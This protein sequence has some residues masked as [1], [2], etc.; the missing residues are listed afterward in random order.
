MERMR[1]VALRL[2]DRCRSP[3][4]V[5]LLMEDYAHFVD[6]IRRAERASSTAWRSCTAATRS[7]PGTQLANSGAMPELVDELLVEHYDPAYLRSIDRNFVQFGAGA[8]AG[9]GRHRGQRLSRG[10]RRR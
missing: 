6:A 5:R 2:A 9:D 10:P 4:R 1:A 8:G 3:N 7:R